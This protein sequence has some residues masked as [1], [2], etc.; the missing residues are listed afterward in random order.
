MYE[1]SELM[2]RIRRL[3]ETEAMDDSVIDRVQ[4]LQRVLLN[5]LEAG[6]E[7]RAELFGDATRSL[8]G[9]GLSESID[10]LGELSLSIDR[11]QSLVKGRK[12]ALIG[13][14]ANPITNGHLTMGLEILALTDVDE[15]WYYLVGK[16]A[17]GKKLMPGK[18]RVAMAKLATEPY[19]R[20]KVC[21]FE[22]EHGDE[23]YDETMET[24]EI[25]RDHFM[26]RFA[27][28]RFAW[29]MGSD[30]AQSF[31]LWKGA[32]WMADAMTFYIIHRLGYEFNKEQSLLA[33]EKHKY[34]CDEIVTSNISSSLVRERGRDYEA[35]KLL[36]LVPNS[37]WN[38]LVEHR[39]LDPERL[40]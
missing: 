33:S 9:L 22:V 27:K 19:S 13:T 12:I 11:A 14:S 34:F 17:W 39:L 16:H 1:W 31:H 2:R 24:A 36:A 40:K 23:F 10:L 15:V 35:S 4:S 28:H 8:M 26:P 21:D 30:V 6:R 5:F 18:H 3:E 37:V 25:M 32:P 29:V 38:Y 7:R 20:L